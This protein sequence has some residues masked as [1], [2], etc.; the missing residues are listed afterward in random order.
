MPA[1]SSPP[2]TT[3]PCCTFAAFPVA[4]APCSSNG[5]STA[6]CGATS[7]SSK[8]PSAASSSA[9]PFS[10]PSSCVS[11]SR[12]C[13]RGLAVDRS[14]H[15]LGP[16]PAGD[17]HHFG[18]VL[19]SPCAQGHQRIGQAAAERGERVLHARR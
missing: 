19:R 7:A 10:W 6:A 2:P 4:H 16:L 14:S 12:R 13:E 11:L 17:V 18:H 8:P 1:R 3:P 15:G 9:R 5:T